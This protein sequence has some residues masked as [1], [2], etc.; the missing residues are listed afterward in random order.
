[1]NNFLIL[2]V[3]VKTVFCSVSHYLVAMWT[4]HGANGELGRSVPPHAGA[5]S[6]CDFGSV[7]T[8][9]LRMGAGAVQG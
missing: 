8:P 6:S 1:M 3:P 5:E 4:V 7:I 2:P 9:P